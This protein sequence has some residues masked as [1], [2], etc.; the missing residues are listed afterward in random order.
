MVTSC[1][2]EPFLAGNTHSYTG[3]PPEFQLTVALTRASGIGVIVVRAR[4][5]RLKELLPLVPQMIE[6]LSKVL[7]GEL[8]NRISSGRMI[9]ETYPYIAPPVWRRG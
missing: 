5:N 1:W 9:N 3:S 4:T 7:P 2:N 8:I 6:A